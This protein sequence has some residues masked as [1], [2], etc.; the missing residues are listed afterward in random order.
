MGGFLSYNRDYKR[1]G[2]VFNTQGFSFQERKIL[3]PFLNHGYTFKTWIKK[4]K[5]KPVI[6]VSG[7]EHSKRRQFVSHP[8]C[9]VGELQTAGKTICEGKL[10]T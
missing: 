1:K 5:E 10:M 7:K 4:N 2:L 3:S 8:H 9:G 6:A